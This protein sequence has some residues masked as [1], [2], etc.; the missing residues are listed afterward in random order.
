[1]VILKWFILVRIMVILKWFILVNLRLTL[2]LAIIKRVNYKR[3]LFSFLCWIRIIL[4]LTCPL[5][6]LTLIYKIIN[7]FNYSFIKFCTSLYYLDIVHLFKSL[8]FWICNIYDIESLIFII[9]V[10]ICILN[11]VQGL[12]IIIQSNITLVGYYSNFN[13]F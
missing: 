6:W 8:N 10:W 4:Y 2:V 12:L 11:F 13:I 3:I 1:M 9:I 7:S 5:G